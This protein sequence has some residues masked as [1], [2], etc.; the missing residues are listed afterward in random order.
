MKRNIVPFL[1][2]AATLV[3]ASC[4]KSEDNETTYYNDT[5][6]SSFT[7]GTLNRYV[8]GKANDGVTDST[9]KTTVTGSQYD[10]YIDHL[11]RKIY[12]LDSLPYGTDV[13]KVLATI[14][15]KNSGRVFIKSMVSD[16]LWVYSSSDSIDFS[17]PREIRV[18]PYSNDNDDYRAYEVKVN[19]H[20]EA[21]DTVFWTKETGVTPESVSVNGFGVNQYKVENGRLMMS[22]EQGTT[23]T[24]ETLDTDASYLPNANVNFVCKGIRTNE[25]TDYVLLVGTS[26]ADRKYASCWFKYD[27]Y[28]AGAAPNGWSYITTGGSNGYLLPKL[29]NLSVACYGE[30][31]ILAIGGEGMDDCTAAPYEAIY[32]SHDNG[33][34]WIPND[35]FRLPEEMDKKATNVKLLVDVNQEL[36]LFCEGTDE[37]WHGR[38]N[39]D[40]KT[41]H[42]RFL[43]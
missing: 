13:S 9:Y 42:K 12:N 5:A 36:W 28:E 10:F 14:S 26:D 19:V 41:A 21:T 8:T 43:E 11:N 4:L 23:W 29:R 16:T 34:S 15:T 2:M 40:D 25:M 1:L 38:L 17:K 22:A 33:I 32:V 27:E 37:V 35:V 6:I 20:Q 30:S 31:E 7:L 18:Y 3:F 24:E 39:R